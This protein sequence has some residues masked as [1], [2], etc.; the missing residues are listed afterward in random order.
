MGWVPAWIYRNYLVEKKL[1]SKMK[2]LYELEQVVS[3]NK[4]PSKVGKRLS[5]RNIGLYPLY[6]PDYSQE[7]V[8]H[9]KSLDDL[10]RGWNPTFKGREERKSPSLQVVDHSLKN[11]KSLIQNVHQAESLK[12]V[13]GKRNKLERGWALSYKVESEKPDY[14]LGKPK[15]KAR[16][17]VQREKL[18]RKLEKRWVGN[19]IHM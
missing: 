17:E 3:S 18:A 16:I 8:H 11:I 1:S 4:H 12:R 14:G 5:R 7:N 10:E 9:G 19:F 13:E 2:R 15:Q 6:A